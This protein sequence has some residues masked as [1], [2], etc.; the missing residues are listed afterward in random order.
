MKLE[1]TNEERGLSNQRRLK[2]HGGPLSCVQVWV[3]FRILRLDSRLINVS[4]KNNCRLSRPPPPTIF[5]TP[6][7]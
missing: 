4:N 7:R 3:D 2:R 1:T 6:E 5:L